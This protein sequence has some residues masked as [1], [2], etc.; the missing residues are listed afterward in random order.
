MKMFVSWRSEDRTTRE[1]AYRGA[2]PTDIVQWCLKSAHVKPKVR[3]VT[4]VHEETLSASESIHHHQPYMIR[5][6]HV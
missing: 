5:Q 1:P 6:A 4:P 3:P 2:Y